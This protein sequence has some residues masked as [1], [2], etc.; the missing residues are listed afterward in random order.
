[1]RTI[2][3]SK[4]VEKRVMRERRDTRGINCE[5]KDPSS[6]P[7]ERKTLWKWETSGGKAELHPM[8]LS[9]TVAGS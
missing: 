5:S 9:E 7:R 3:K 6:F 4:Q 1:M 8:K 2:Y